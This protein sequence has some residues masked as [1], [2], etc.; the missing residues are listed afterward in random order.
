M[1]DPYLRARATLE[2]DL[3]RD[4]PLGSLILPGERS[5]QFSGWVELTSAIESWRVDAVARFE[6]PDRPKRKDDQ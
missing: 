1:A 2:L 4:P 3:R 6:D 5:R